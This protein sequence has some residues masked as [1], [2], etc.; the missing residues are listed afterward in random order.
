MRKFFFFCW[1]QRPQTQSWRRDTSRHFNQGAMH[2]TAWGGGGTYSGLS[3]QIE[4]QQEPSPNSDSGAASSHRAQPDLRKHVQKR[5]L[6]LDL[7]HGSLIGTRV[8]LNALGCVV[9]HV[10]NPVLY[11]E[12]SNKYF[13]SIRMFVWATW[14]S[15]TKEHSYEYQLTESFVAYHCHT[16]SARGCF[17]S[18]YDNFLCSLRWEVLSARWPG[19]LW[20]RRTCFV[21]LMTALLGG[22][23]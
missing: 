9:A 7:S 22:E 10:I 18:L 21:P 1:H 6:A 19:F 23:W 11:W 4:M 5:K 12:I 3:D 14:Y 17:L 16:S 20:G 15:Q 8:V 2:W 13:M